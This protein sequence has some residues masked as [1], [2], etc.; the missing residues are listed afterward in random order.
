ML[1]PA[2]WFYLVVLLTS[3][4]SIPGLMMAR[5]GHYNFRAPNLYGSTP[6]R[7]RSIR[8]WTRWFCS[9]AEAVAETKTQ[10]GNGRESIGN[11]C[12]L[13]DG[14]RRVKGQ[15]WLMTRRWAM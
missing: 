7:L 6:P 14:L 9:A 15:E 5:R 12:E 10:H 13:R 1:S 2:R 4:R 11:N 3:I 8:T